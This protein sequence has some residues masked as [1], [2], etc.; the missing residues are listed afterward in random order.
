MLST[1]LVFSTSF[2]VSAVFDGEW[3]LAKIPE[4][5]NRHPSV[6][7]Q[8]LGIEFHPKKDSETV[9]GTI[10]Y[11]N[12]KNTWTL[13][14]VDDALI[15][16]V[17]V[18]IEDEK[19]ILTSIKGNNGIKYEMEMSATE[20]TLI[21]TGKYEGEEFTMTFGSENS[22]T[23]TYGINNYALD[24]HISSDTVPIPE[25]MFAQEESPSNFVEYLLLKYKKF[26]PVVYTAIAIIV[27]QVIVI[28]FLCAPEPPK[29][30][31]KRQRKELAARK[32]AEEEKK[33]QEEEAAA[34]KEKAENNEEEEKKEGNEEEQK[35]EEEKDEGK[36]EEDEDEYA[37][38]L[39]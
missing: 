28:K 16:K 1:L 30:L 29:K 14:S 7:E 25:Y 6:L 33:R 2:D 21:L 5:G 3:D 8:I 13:K 31:T 37:K 11:N 17:E 39:Q 36:L 10:W 12:Q 18:E 38:S 4:N 24:R 19:V 22:G 9:I 34:K 15:D 20:D 23:L 26:L 35:K 27:A 32:A